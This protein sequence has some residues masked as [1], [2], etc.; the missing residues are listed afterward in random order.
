MKVLLVGDGAREHAIAEALARSPQEPKIYALCSHA[1]PGIK[2]I[3]EATG[4]SIIKGK[5]TS[6][7]DA[8]K[9]AKESG[10]ELVVVGPEEPLFHGV[11]DAI[12]AELG[13]PVFGAKSRLAEIER[14]KVWMR[15]LL[16]KYNIPGRLA[17]R[18]FKRLDEALEYL[19]HAGNVALKPARQAGGK[20]V[21]V[22]ADLQAY[23]A[24]EKAEIRVLHAKRIVEEVMAKYADIEE[25]VLVEERVEGPEYTV[26]CI[27]DG[28]TVLPLPA[29]QDHPH[30]FELD[31]GPETGGMGSI[32]DGTRI[33]LPFLTEEEYEK[34]VEIV[35]KTVEALEKETGE[36]YRGVISGQMML[37][38]LWGP[39]VIEYYSRFGDPEAC[40]VLPLIESDFLDIV[41]RAA[42]GRLAGA[43]LKL[44]EGV[45]T[46]VKAVAP[47]GYPDARSLAKGH[48]LAIDQEAIEKLGCKVYY[49]AV[50]ENLTTTGSRAVE[51]VG[52]APT[53]EE[54]SA[55][56]EE[57]IREHIKAL[58]GWK[59]IH[60]S[61]I[62]TKWLL[63]RRIE[64]AE[65]VRAVY[66]YRVKKGLL[67]KKVDWVP[68]VG[69]VEFDYT[70][71]MEL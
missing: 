31:L 63:Q 39:T 49:G 37:T 50:D 3:C 45:A 40:N 8:V 53:L 38:A 19:K 54:A 52:F 68:G 59:L 51:V 61:D 60:R 12:E 28:S 41:Y 46:V 14:S 35:K 58:D 36:K 56:A 5:P 22:I 16:W 1:N 4:G 29:V 6:P 23:L 20:G 21:K 33:G 67:G 44:R 25:K 13:L 48:K 69:L 32:Y 26:M 65:K 66:T 24:K 42:T 57:A 71:P 17:F 7:T 9:A 10:A 47:L 55:R 64:E 62:G 15:R 30:A 34:T 11:A 2:R 70:K 18:A 27:T 43:K